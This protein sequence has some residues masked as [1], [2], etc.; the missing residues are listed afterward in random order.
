MEKLPNTKFT[1]IDGSSGQVFAH[2]R[3][4]LDVSSNICNMEEDTPFV[5]DKLHQL[6]VY[7]ITL[8]Y[9]IM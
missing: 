1:P 8:H 3:S 9:G 2:G 5:R 7:I 6:S 4:E